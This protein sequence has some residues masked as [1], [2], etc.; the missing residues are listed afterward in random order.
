[1]T[2]LSVGAGETWSCPTI[3][4]WYCDLKDF[5]EK[6]EPVTE[7]E[8][9]MLDRAVPVLALQGFGLACLLLAA[10]VIYDGWYVVAALG[11]ALTF[12]RTDDLHEVILLTR[13]VVRRRLRDKPD[14]DEPGQ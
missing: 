11:L 6:G 9:T 13:I 4:T 2:R 12:G 5:T 1:M 14:R 10:L 8:R 7:A 3:G